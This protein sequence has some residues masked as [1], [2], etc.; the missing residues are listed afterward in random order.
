MPAGWT[1]LNEPGWCRPARPLSWVLGTRGASPQVTVQSRKLI[2]GHGARGSLWVRERGS[3]GFRKVP[4]GLSTLQLLPCLGRPLFPIHSC[5]LA[6]ST[7]AQDGG[8]VF[9]FFLL[10]VV[11]LLRDPFSLCVPQDHT[12]TPNP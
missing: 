8:V 4:T 2:R 11:P 5:P 3:W 6:A 10:G 12:S 1:E 7:K 9:F